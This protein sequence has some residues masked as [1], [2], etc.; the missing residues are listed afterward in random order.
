MDPFKTEVKNENLKSEQKNDNGQYS[1]G[2]NTHRRLSI[3]FLHLA[4]LN[5]INDKFKDIILEDTWQEMEH[6]N[7]YHA[8]F[9]VMYS[10]YSKPQDFQEEWHHEDP[11]EHKYWCM[12]ILN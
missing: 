6:I 4:S 12:S 8:N 10:S 11:E 9:N 1:R 3:P 5:Q 7:Q 2:E